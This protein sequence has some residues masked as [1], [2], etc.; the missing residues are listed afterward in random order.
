MNDETPLPQD[1]QEQ[2]AALFRITPTAPAW[3]QPISAE[4]KAALDARIQAWQASP[5]DEDGPFS[6]HLLTGGDVWYLAARALTA[7]H[8]DPAFMEQIFR[9]ALVTG[10]G[11]SGAIMLKDQPNLHLE[12]ARLQR[13]DLREALLQRAGLTGADLWGAFLNRAVLSAAHLEGANLNRATLDDARLEGAYLNGA[14]LL[15][16]SLRGA[17]LVRT[18][19]DE[20]DLAGADLEGANLR[21]ASF[22]KRTRLNEVKLNGALLEQATFD[23]TDLTVLEW[24]MVRRLGDETWARST[25]KPALQGIDDSPPPPLVPK[26]ASERTEEYRRAG[27][28]YRSLAVVLRSQGLTAASGRFDTRAELMECHARWHQALVESHGAEHEKRPPF[29]RALHTAGGVLESFASYVVYGLVWL[30]AH[31][32]ALALSYVLLIAA[33]TLVYLLAGQ[34]AH[35]GLDLGNAFVFSVTSFHGR[36]L[37]PGQISRQRCA[38]SHLPK[39]WWAYLSKLYLL[40][41]LYVA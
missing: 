28:A 9:D 12:G 10:P 32:W 15:Q 5:I 20:A 3:G 8:D 29:Q 13:A 40:R 39:Q 1:E 23:G 4:R 24:S 2:L 16:A 26:R 14:S 19:L 37:R 7:P 41:L 30:A 27:R 31:L 11:G 6:G 35:T 36:G 33:F 22:D 17:V 21:G 38:T 34:Q 18:M 25:K